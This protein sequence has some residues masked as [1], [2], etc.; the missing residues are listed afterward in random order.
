MLRRIRQLQGN[1][2]GASDGEIGQVKDFYFDDPRR[3]IRDVVVATGTW[4]AGR[5]AFIS[6][7][8]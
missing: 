3:A 5:A 8:Q 4:L 1:T 2:L 6:R 7:S